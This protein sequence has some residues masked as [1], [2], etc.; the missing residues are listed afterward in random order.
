MWSSMLTRIMSSMRIRALLSAQ[1]PETTVEFS[2][3]VAVVTGAASGMGRAC[4]ERLRDV[5]DSLVAVDLQAPDIDRT[6]G[7][8]CDISDADAVDALV[9]RVREFGPFRA[10]AH[11]AGISPTMAGA[12][13]VFEV[14]LVGTQLLLD[15]FEALV[16]PGSAA[17]CFASSAAY[18]IAPFADAEIDALIDEP[19][20]PD[21]LDRAATA[22]ADSGL[23]YGLAKRGVIRAVGR[24]AVRWGPRGGRVNSVSPGLIDTPMGRQEF[25]QQPIM[26][27][28]F[29]RTALGRFGE[30][31][32]VADVVAYLVSDAA[33]F[34][35]GIDVLVDG[36]MTQGMAALGAA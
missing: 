8:A 3:T 10:L 19:L 34:I 35:T 21:F 29:E 9:A 16:V 12:R 6:V 27:E 1:P 20:A 25:A 26:R 30:P 13:R 11:S 33:S 18:S 17:V 23:A 24:A 32:E 15:G 2:M 5:A 36:G 14:D 31:G 7:V 22:Y 28:M 4:I